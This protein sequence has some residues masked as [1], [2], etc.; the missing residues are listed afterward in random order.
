LVTDN[1]Y[2]TYITYVRHWFVISY[3]HDRMC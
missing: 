1:E 2:I 3:I